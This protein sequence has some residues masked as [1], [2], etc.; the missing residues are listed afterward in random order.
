MFEAV[1]EYR[2]AVRS[3]GCVPR[4]RLVCRVDYGRKISETKHKHTRY[5]SY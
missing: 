1:G 5:L 4:H 3:F 2:V